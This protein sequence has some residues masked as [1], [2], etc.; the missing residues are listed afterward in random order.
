MQL[1][2]KVVLAVAPLLG[3]LF[4]VEC[5]KHDVLISIFFKYVFCKK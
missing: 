4:T 5:F 2:Q 1:S 3:P